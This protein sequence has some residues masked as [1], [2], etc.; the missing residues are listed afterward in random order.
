MLLILHLLSCSLPQ[1]TAAEQ[2]GLPRMDGQKQQCVAKLS[3]KVGLLAFLRRPGKN[4]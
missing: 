3:M 4:R 2:R 1:G